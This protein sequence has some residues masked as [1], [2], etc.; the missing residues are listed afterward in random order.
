M[1]DGGDSGDADKCRHLDQS[2]EGI[3]TVR[4]LTS[5]VCGWKTEATRF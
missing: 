3:W 5:N 4:K 2:I 1:P